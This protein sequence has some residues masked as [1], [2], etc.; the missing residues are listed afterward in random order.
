[1]IFQVATEGSFEPTAGSRARCT[2]KS[3][4]NN[5]V[6]QNYTGTGYRDGSLPLPLP[7]PLPLSH[8]AAAACLPAC[9]PA[10]AL[11]TTA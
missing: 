9:L 11:A 6:N 4:N 7:L 5:F 1:M 2:I 10:Q 3:V 8:S